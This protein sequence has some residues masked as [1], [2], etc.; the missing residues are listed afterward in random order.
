MNKNKVAITEATQLREVEA[1][2]FTALQSK[3][4]AEVNLANAEVIQA[5]LA[6]DNQQQLFKQEQIN[7]QRMSRQ[8][9]AGEID[10]LALTFVKLEDNAAE[11]SLA[12]GYFQLKTAVNTLE[13]TLQKP[14][15]SSRFKA[16]ALESPEIKDE[17]KYEP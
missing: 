11:K 13:N 10:R 17:M 3:V 5:K 1:A 4:I 9:T 14:L 6:L 2:Q 16:T 12:L 15:I 7:S 8:F